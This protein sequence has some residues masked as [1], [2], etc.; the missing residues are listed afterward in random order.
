VNAVSPGSV[1][2]RYLAGTVAVAAAAA[3][4]GLWALFVRPAALPAATFSLLVFVTM[5][6]V[7]LPLAL[8]DA[9]ATWSRR[10][11]LLLVANGLCDALNVLTYFAALQRTSV[12]IAVMTHYL[13][14]VLIAALAPWV[15]RERVPGAVPGTLI[16]LT[17]LMMVLQPHEGVSSADLAGALLGAASAVAYCGNVF[18]VRRLTPLIGAPR[19]MSYHSF[20]GAAIMAPF[21]IHAGVTPGAESLGWVVS[22]AV[23][24]GALSGVAFLRGLAIIGSSRAAMLTYLEPVVAVAVGVIAWGERLDA[25]AV[26][27]IALILGSGAWV[28]RPRP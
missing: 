11:V 17:G 22:G 23:T 8:R 6:L 26:A 20:I 27:G 7:L 5:G 16:A 2:G 3:S 21:A 10:A 28:A 18:V 12:A 19:T 1:S 9:P 4:W 24:I 13:A 14:P 25:L 15:E